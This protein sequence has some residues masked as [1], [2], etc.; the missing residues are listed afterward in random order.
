MHRIYWGTPLVQE[1]YLW[2]TKW[3]KRCRWY[4]K[5]I[6]SVPTMTRRLVLVRGRKPWPNSGRHSW[7]ESGVE[8]HFFHPMHMSG[9]FRHTLS[10]YMTT[11]KI[12]SFTYRFLRRNINGLQLFK[13]QCY[14]RKVSRLLYSTQIITSQ[15]LLICF[16]MPPIWL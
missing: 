5:R 1:A 11:M 7:L 13:Y 8:S 9:I 16:T 2:C 10:Y 4:R 12:R 6:S 15:I 3:T 14:K